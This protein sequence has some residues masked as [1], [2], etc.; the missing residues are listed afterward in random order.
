MTETNKDQTE[1]KKSVVKN[2]Y[3]GIWMPLGM[4]F[5]AAIGMVYGDSTNGLVYGMLAGIVIGAVMDQKNAKQTDTN[6]QPTENN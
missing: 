3:I 1:A 4:A 6:N 2:K 5:G